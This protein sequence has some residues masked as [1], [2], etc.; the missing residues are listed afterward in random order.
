M[1]IIHSKKRSA[2]W[3]LQQTNNALVT[4][5]P[6]LRDRPTTNLLGRPVLFTDKTPYTNGSVTNTVNLVDPSMYVVSE[7]QG[8]ALAVSDQARFEQDQTVIRAI[9][10]V[11][12]QPWLTNKIAVTSTPDYASGFVTI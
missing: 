2:V 4:L 11:D 10:S 7:F 8:I 3:S 1:W 6:N 12:G 9:M 5:L